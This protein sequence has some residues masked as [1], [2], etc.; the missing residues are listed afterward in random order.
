MRDSF[1]CL[2]CKKRIYFDPESQ[3]TDLQLCG[4][5]MGKFDTDKLWKMHDQSKLDALD[6]NES[7]AFRERFRIKKLKKVA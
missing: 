1:T 6:F 2:E 5:C 7:K 4:K 3:G